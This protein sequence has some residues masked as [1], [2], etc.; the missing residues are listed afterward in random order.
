MVKQYFCCFWLETGVTLIGL[1][2]INAAIWYFFQWTTFKPVY[3][4]FDLF[5]SLIYMARSG[6]FLH[7]S[8]KDDMFATAK[9]R[10]LYCKVNWI[11]ALALA[12][13]IILKLIVYWTDWGHF[14]LM[15]FLGWIVLAILNIY[16]HIVLRS[17]ANF[18]DDRSSAM[19]DIEKENLH[20][21]RGDID[22][23]LT[24]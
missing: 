20:S 9:S 22:T 17:F 21:S 15:S 11:S 3:S 12:L 7:G 6:V 8:F 23:P 14:P 13:V 19:P 5:T 24:I 18:E 1:L 2:H 10:D 4:W 16:H